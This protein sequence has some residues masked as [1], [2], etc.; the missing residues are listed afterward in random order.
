MPAAHSI[1]VPLR[2]VG[3]SCRVAVWEHLSFPAATR[4]RYCPFAASDPACACAALSGA[5]LALRIAAL[6]RARES[7]R[8]GALT[9]W[10]LRIQRRMP[11]DGSPRSVPAIGLLLF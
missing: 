5:G 11:R 4:Q 8:I 1:G 2:Q 10:P 9:A 3:H 6:Y 7:R